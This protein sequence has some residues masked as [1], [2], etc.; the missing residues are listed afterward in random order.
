MLV[1]L[2]P[3]V[4]SR[5]FPAPKA[6]LVPPVPMALLVPPAPLVPMVSPV[7]LVPKV[8]LAMLV[9][10]VLPVP[11]VPTETTV[12]MAN[13]VPLALATTALPRV[14]PPAIKPF[15]HFPNS[16]L[17]SEWWS[18]SIDSPVALVFFVS[19]LVVSSKP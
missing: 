11:L 18:G 8:P 1:P 4:S 6:P 5:R 9:P 19:F 7:L 2:V 13:R 16:E 10:M 3:P 17:Q 15:H 14:Q 12:P